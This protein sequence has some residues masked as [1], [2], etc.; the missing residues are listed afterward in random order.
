MTFARRFGLPRLSFSKASS[1]L[2]QASLASPN[3]K[4][5]LHALDSEKCLRRTCQ[6]YKFL[7][8]K[9]RWLQVLADNETERAQRVLLIRYHVQ[10]WTPLIQPRLFIRRAALTP[11]QTRRVPA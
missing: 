1:G 6:K 8:L 5:A 7:D 3:A 10:L 4:P 11:G 2:S 9:D